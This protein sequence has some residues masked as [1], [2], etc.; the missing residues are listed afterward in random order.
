M[1]VEN[2][3]NLPGEVRKVVR[4]WFWFRDLKDTEV[5]RQRR[6]ELGSEAAGLQHGE[7]DVAKPSDSSVPTKSLEFVSLTGR[8]AGLSLSRRKI[9]LRDKRYQILLT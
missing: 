4:K 9:Y 7:A 2:A 5:C 3:Q 1:R 6:D 8:P